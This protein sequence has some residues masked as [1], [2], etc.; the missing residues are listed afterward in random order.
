MTLWDYFIC[1][2]YFR[3]GGKLDP[4][5]RPQ[6]EITRPSIIRVIFK[7]HRLHPLPDRFQ[8]TEHTVIPKN[9]RYINYALGEGSLDN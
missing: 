2:N 8:F 5:Y 3:L 9:R 4:V 1:G 7:I 6:I